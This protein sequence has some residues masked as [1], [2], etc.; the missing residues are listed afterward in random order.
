[1]L[2]GQRVSMF[3]F[4]VDLLS[5]V[6][7]STV[8]DFDLSTRVDLSIMSTCQPGFKPGLY[9]FHNTF[10]YYERSYMLTSDL[11]PY[12]ILITKIKYCMKFIEKSI[13]RKISCKCDVTLSGFGIASVQ[14]ISG[15]W[16]QF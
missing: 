16:T 10:M 11:D 8:N 1:M 5:W 14:T 13:E 15:D 9:V 2:K 3:F 12:A 4:T 7:M 6:D